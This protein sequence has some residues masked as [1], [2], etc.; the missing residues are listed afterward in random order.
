MT[1]NVLMGTLNPTQSLT[2]SLSQSCLPNKEIVFS[3]KPV[4]LPSASLPVL[5]VTIGLYKCKRH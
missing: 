3:G 2:H 1:Y 5:K 4:L